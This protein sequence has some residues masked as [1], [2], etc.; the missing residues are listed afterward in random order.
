VVNWGDT[1]WE[2]Q[3]QLAETEGMPIEPTG[4]TPICRHCH[5]P[6]P[7]LDE[8]ENPRYQG[9]CPDCA[10]AARDMDAEDA[11]IISHEDPL[12]HLRHG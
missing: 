7:Y 3:A 1:L 2:H 10:E 8:D 4:R 11:L 9:L 5:Q 6:Y 12:N